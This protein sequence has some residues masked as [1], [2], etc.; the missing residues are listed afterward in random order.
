MKKQVISKLREEEPPLGKFMMYELRPVR[1]ITLPRLP[2]LVTM[3]ARLPVWGLPV[4]VQY[5]KRS[6][7]IRF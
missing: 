5:A 2:W 1:V 4:D 6:I 3:A 7:K